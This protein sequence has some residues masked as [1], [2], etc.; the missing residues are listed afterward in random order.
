MAFA[1]NEDPPIA[2]TALQ[3]LWDDRARKLLDACSQTNPFAG[4]KTWQQHLRRRRNPADPKFLSKREPAILWGWL[5][6]WDRDAIQTA[7]Q[8]RRRSPKS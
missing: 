1:I 7:I 6:E 4:W 2:L 8:P 5:R 3:P